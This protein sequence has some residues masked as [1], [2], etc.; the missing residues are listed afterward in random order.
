MRILLFALLFV[1]IWTQAQ[2]GLRTW[3]CF[4]YRKVDERAPVI[5]LI[6]SEDPS[7]AL[8][9]WAIFIFDKQI[10]AYFKL[11]GL[12]HTW[13]FGDDLNYTLLIKPNGLGYYY[14]F[15]GVKVGEETNPKDIYSCV[16]S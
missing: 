15:T 13:L 7:S 12:E 1:P 2:V 16:K 10:E 14:D 3:K 5:T 4:E 6:D 8:D 9:K 11:K